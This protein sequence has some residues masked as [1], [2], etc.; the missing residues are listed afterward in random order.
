MMYL[1]LAVLLFV[2]LLF[3]VWATVHVDKKIAED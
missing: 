2:A 3:G 1:V